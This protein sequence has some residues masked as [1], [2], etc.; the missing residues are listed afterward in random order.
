LSEELFCNG[1]PN[2][3]GI[4]AD[5]VLYGMV[6]NAMSSPSA[7]FL[8][9][10]NHIQD[11]IVDSLDFGF[12]GLS[13]DLCNCN[14]NFVF[15]HGGEQAG[16][17]VGRRDP[18]DTFDQV[19]DWIMDNPRNVL[20]IHMQMNSAADGPVTLADLQT[21]LEQVPNGFVDRIYHHD[22]TI[23]TEW[24][25]LEELIRAGTQVILFYV[26]SP[27]GSGVHPPGI[28]YF[29]DYGMQ[30]EFSYE[31]VDDLRDTLGS[32]S[33]RSAGSGG[34]REWF[35]I[36]AFVTRVQFGVQVAPSREA[37]AEINTIQ[38]SEP[39]LDACEQFHGQ[40]VNL[41]VVDFW[42]EGNLP[43]LVDQHNAALV[44]PA[45]PPTPAPITASPTFPVTGTPSGMPTETSSD[46]PTTA[47][48][49]IPTGTT[50]GMPSGSPAPT[51]T[52]IPTGP[53]ARPSIIPSDEPSVRPSILPT[54]APNDH[55]STTPTVRASSVP[56]NMPTSTPTEMTSGNPTAAPKT[57]APSSRDT[58][59]APPTSTPSVFSGTPTG[60]EGDAS[61]ANT[62]TLSFSSILSLSVLLIMMV[63]K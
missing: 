45:A 54:H 52:G 59:S 14:G 36:N 12:R 33:L 10:A 21:I 62:T 17:G 20:V 29:F 31:S 2:L 42:S 48:S 24:P 51:S 18:V 43:A 53:S 47:P 57:G 7:G 49:Q 4:P 3:C 39:L 19:N 30:N 26:S 46:S 22:P 25:T 61:S 1:L 6:H 8:V 13:L 41:I 44:P 55:P 37:A 11:P 15:C 32:C 27:N 5:E 38:F 50:T 9:F 56:S 28:H 34:T 58:S 60:I 40:K 63:P 16:C 23:N 35:L